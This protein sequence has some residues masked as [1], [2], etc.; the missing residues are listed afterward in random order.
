M[1]ILDIKVYGHATSSLKNGSE[2]APESSMDT[3]PHPIV[4]REELTAFTEVENALLSIG[5]PV[6]VVTTSEVDY[7]SSSSSPMFTRGARRV[8][9]DP[10]TNRAV[11]EL[12]CW[13]EKAVKAEEYDEAT[14][15]AS[16]IDTL[17][18]QG[19]LI[20][21]LE[22]EERTSV[23]VEAFEKAQE[24]QQMLKKVTRERDHSMRA[25]LTLARAFD[26]LA[27]SMTSCLRGPQSKSESGKSHRS[28]RQS[29]KSYTHDSKPQQ[30][31]V[32]VISYMYE[33]FSNIHSQIYYSFI[34]SGK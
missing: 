8:A 17:C 33:I 10:K 21:N 26:D 27:A 16:D 18:R 9:L 23:A 30:T 1:G 34:E 12:R 5:I 24:A 19:K 4:P 25:A 15:L 11:E 22:R 2:S 28:K 29:G 7:A 14:R 32:Q 3:P 6:E 20:C 31:P 13:K